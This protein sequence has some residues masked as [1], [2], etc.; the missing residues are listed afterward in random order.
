MSV[1]DAVA[2]Y[3]WAPDYPWG[4]PVELDQQIDD[5]LCADWGRPRL[6]DRRGRFAATAARHSGFVEWAI[7]WFRRGAGPATFAAQSEV[8]RAGDVRAALSA[9]RCPTLIINHADVEDGRFLAAHIG[10]ARY[11]ELH[12]RFICC[13][14]PSSMR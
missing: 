2:R 12:D 14:Q 11:V 13:S 7:T 3:R 9:I 10:D 4:V 8:L 6:A 1:Y 5:Q